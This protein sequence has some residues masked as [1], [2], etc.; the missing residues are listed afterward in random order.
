MS[1]KIRLAFLLA[2]S[3]WLT[4]CIFANID[5]SPESK[6]Y[7]ETVVKAGSGKKLALIDIHGGITDHAPSAPLF[8]QAPESMMKRVLDQL[9][10]ARNDSDVAGIILKIDSPGGTVTASD[11][12][13]RE[14]TK[15]KKDT[16]KTVVAVLMD[17]A[18]SGGYYVAVA[19]DKIVAHPTTVTG[20][21]GVIMQTFNLAG[22]LEKI[23]V[24][25]TP[26]K[27]AA[28]KDIGSPFRGST[29]AEKE[30][31][32]AIIDEMYLTFLEKVREGRPG[33]KPST[34]KEMA[35]GR[36]FT[37]RVAQKAGF[38]DEIGYIEDSFKVAADLSGTVNPRVIRYHRENER[39]NGVYAKSSQGKQTP[40][41][42]VD[43][44]SILEPLRPG[45]YYYWS[46][47]RIGLGG[48]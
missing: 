20:S 33:L 39:A 44:G 40:L 4:G 26:I 8:G 18:A 17:T 21:I 12:L 43:F 37:G 36:V 10:K 30:V 45:F 34:L 23:G 11:I 28:K 25:V 2:A 32:Q 47:G 22:L 46:P 9:S 1:P 3:P 7:T 27:S 19:A 5:L 29:A 35:D 38:V 15:F 24:E 6:P 48:R 13:H 16:G 41:V 42:N 31:L 14:I